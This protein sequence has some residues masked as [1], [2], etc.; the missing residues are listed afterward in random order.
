MYVYNKIQVQF[1]MYIIVYCIGR[2][3]NLIFYFAYLKL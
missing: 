1:I 2:F 3:G